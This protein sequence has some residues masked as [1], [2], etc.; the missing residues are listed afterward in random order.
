VSRLDQKAFV[1]SRTG[2]A[3]KFLATLSVRN[4]LNNKDPEVSPLATFAARF[5]R[6][7]N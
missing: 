6:D 4:S 1:D 5:Q 3:Q 2:G 7:W